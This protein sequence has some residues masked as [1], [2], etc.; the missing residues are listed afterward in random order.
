MQHNLNPYYDV[1]D[2]WDKIRKKLFGS[3]KSCSSFTPWGITW[4]PFHTSIESFFPYKFYT[5]LN[6]FTLAIGHCKK[7]HHYSKQ[8]K[9]MKF[10][11]CNCNEIMMEAIF[12]WFAKKMKSNKLIRV[13]LLKATTIVKLEIQVLAL[14]QRKSR[15]ANARNIIWG[16]VL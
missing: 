15:G 10:L 5:C 4:A 7:T 9:A 12:S 14:C 1:I 6:N 16:I 3:A 8:E 11:L 2:E 13:E